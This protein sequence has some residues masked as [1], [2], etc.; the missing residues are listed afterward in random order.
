MGVGRQTPPE[1]ALAHRGS[2][3]LRARSER[4]C[5]DTYALRVMRSSR[6]R[7]SSR[8]M[9]STTQHMRRRSAATPAPPCALPEAHSCA[10]AAG[11]RT[12]RCISRRRQP[13]A[14]GLLAQARPTAT[15]PHGS[16]AGQPRL[17]AARPSSGPRRQQE[18]ARLS[19]V[20]RGLDEGVQCMSVGER[21]Q[22][23]FPAEWGYGARGF[24]GLVPPNTPLEFDLELVEIM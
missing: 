9:A 11:E 14:L 2:P 21:V 22:L 7:C 16:R 24:P 20:V 15:I 1:A 18:R 13:H 3:P 23:I 6:L 10:R 8:E 5:P 12:L 17:N 19:Q 4:G